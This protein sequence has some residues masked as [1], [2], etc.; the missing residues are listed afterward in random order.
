MHP[1]PKSLTIALASRFTLNQIAQFHSD[2]Q[3]AFSH[4]LPYFFAGS[5]IFPAALRAVTHGRILRQVAESMTPAVVRSFKRHAVR[6][7]SWPA[8]LPST[9]PE[10][11]V[12]GMLVFGMLDS[13]RKALHAFQGSMF[14]LR[15]VKV[16]VE[17]VGGGVVECEAGIY[18]WNR[19]EGSLVT[20]EEREWGIGDL[21]GSEWFAKV[22]AGTVEE[23][24]LLGLEEVDGT[25]DVSM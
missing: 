21:M 15:R 17:L 11:A 2:A 14:D 16:E 9:S 12:E 1:L 19:G 6:G 8:M 22:I 18:V 3:L 23:E 10:D 24:R 5:F 13:Q 25:R 4:P 20:T 7:M